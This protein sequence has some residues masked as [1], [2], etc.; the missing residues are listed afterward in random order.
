MTAQPDP[1]RQQI[2]A[3]VSRV[4]GLPV[5]RVAA[6]VGPEDVDTWDSARHVELVLSLEEHFD[7]MFSPEEVPELTSI[8][9]M[10]DILRRHCKGIGG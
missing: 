3:I 7:C 1:L 4:F 6:G 2:V 8:E 10:Q 9:Q 5:E